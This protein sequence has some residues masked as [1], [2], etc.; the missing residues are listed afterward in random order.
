[1]RGS[2]LRA[3]TGGSNAEP[4]E[5]SARDAAFGGA[6]GLKRTVHHY[7]D[8]S[9]APRVS[10][11]SAFEPGEEETLDLSSSPRFSPRLRVSASKWNLDNNRRQGGALGARRSKEKPHRFRPQTFGTESD[12]ARPGRA[13]DPASGYLARFLGSIPGQVRVLFSLPETPDNYRY[14]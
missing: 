6:P 14:W 9:L 13:G 5:D 7:A 1:M 11:P 4:A 12:A 3:A 10:A 2:T 8:P